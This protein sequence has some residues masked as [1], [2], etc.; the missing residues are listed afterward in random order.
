MSWCLL[1]P[2]S[3]RQKLAH[4]GVSCILEG[5]GLQMTSSK[6]GAVGTAEVYKGGKSG[7]EEA[8]GRDALGR[9]PPPT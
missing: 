9:A 5:A 6:V 2:V 4:F 7:R 8:K 1:L 3:P